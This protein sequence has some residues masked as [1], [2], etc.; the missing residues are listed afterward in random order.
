MRGRLLNMPAL[1]RAAG[2]ALI[3]TLI[4]AAAFHSRHGAGGPGVTGAIAARPD[5]LA[6]ELARCQ[7]IGLAAQGD[8]ACEAAWAQSRRRFF[9]YRQPAEGSAGPEAPA[10]RT[11]R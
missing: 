9:T 2:F 6:G 3:A 1:G 11:G 10:I 4:V 5:P 8:S 7:A